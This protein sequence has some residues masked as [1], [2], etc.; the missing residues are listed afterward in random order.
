MGDLGRP[1][2]R[3]GGV[4]RCRAGLGDFGSGNFIA[5]MEKTIQSTDRLPPILSEAYLRSRYGR[6]EW[7]AYLKATRRT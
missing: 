7:S 2:A 1:A 4:R 5:E 6:L 3:G